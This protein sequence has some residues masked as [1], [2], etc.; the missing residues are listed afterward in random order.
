MDWIEVQ[1]QAPPDRRPVLTWGYSWVCG[2]K[3]GGHCLGFA[4][5]KPGADGGF[6]IE[7][8]GLLHLTYCLVTHWLEVKG[9]DLGPSRRHVPPRPFPSRAG[10]P[11]IQQ[12]MPKG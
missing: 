3:R 4:K 9:P 2:I 11:E 7:A 8:P 6:D 5:Y 12:P 10:D 1:E